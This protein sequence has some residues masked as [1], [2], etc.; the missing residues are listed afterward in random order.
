MDLAAECGLGLKT[1]AEDSSSGPRSSLL[2]PLE[3]ADPRKDR[4]KS[5]VPGCHAGMVRPG[6]TCRTV[7]A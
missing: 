1:G 5:L 3:L 6:P 7:N 4:L 2:Q